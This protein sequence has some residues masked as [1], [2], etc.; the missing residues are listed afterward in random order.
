ML[1]KEPITKRLCVKIIKSYGRRNLIAA[2]I[3]LPLIIIVFLLGLQLAIHYKSNI[4]AILYTLFAVILLV[5]ITYSVMD[6]IIDLIKLYSGRFYIVE[7]PLL[8][9]TQKEHLTTRN[10]RYYL[11]YIFKFEEYGNYSFSYEMYPFSKENRMEARMADIITEPNEE[12]YLLVRGGKKK[13][14]AAVFHKKLFS[15]SEFDFHTS[16]YGKY[17]L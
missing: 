12:F 11:E 7:A 8:S 9:K 14:I 17:Y 3:V 10:R 15:L 6:Y 1:L 2:S 13:K 16:L 4:A 5:L